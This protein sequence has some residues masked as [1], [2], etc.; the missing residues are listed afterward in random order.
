MN[1]PDSVDTSSDYAEEGSHLHDVMQVLMTARMRNNKR[2]LYT[3]ASTF[4]GKH[5][6]DRDFTREYLETAIEPAL[7]SLAELERKYG[8][9]FKVVGVELECHFPGIPGAFGTSD[10]L[11]QS[12][13]HV[14]MPDWKFGQGVPVY[15]TYPSEPDENGV[16][17]EIVNAQILFYMCGAYACFPD[18]F[19]NREMVGAIIQPRIERHMSHTVITP[20][21]LKYF[22]QDLEKAIIEALGRNPYRKRGE[23]CRFA[24]CKLTC[25]LWTGPQLDLSVLPG[26]KQKPKDAES[27][28]PTDFG[29]YLAAAKELVEDAMLFKATLDQEI[30]AFLEAGG[31]V[32]GWRLKPKQKNRQWVAE[33][34][35]VPAL[36]KLGFAETDIWQRKLQTFTSADATAKR[37]G[38]S[39]PAH[40][41]VAPATN[42]TTVCRTDDPAPTVPP[43]VTAAKFAEALKK[44]KAPT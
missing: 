16:V 36:K 23:H 41:R 28:K 5:F 24:A 27:R 1:L 11:L 7:D 6:Y 22:A 32:P 33:T 19:G 40:L 38:V 34:E 26:V 3:M 25:K 21:E 4:V 18:L 39:I 12:K 8:G 10:V 15:A 44:L 17:G 14:L 35:V 13:S 29:L 20:I 9:G 30:H 37:L 2:D 42:E 43:P 31:I